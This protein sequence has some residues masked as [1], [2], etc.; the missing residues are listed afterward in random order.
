MVKSI[1]ADRHQSLKKLDE[2]AKI[3]PISTRIFSNGLKRFYQDARETGFVD[4]PSGAGVKAEVV[5][6]LNQNRI[7]LSNRKTRHQMVEFCIAHHIRPDVFGSIMDQ[8][9]KVNKQ[10]LYWGENLKRD[11][12][13]NSCLL[14]TSP[15]P[16]D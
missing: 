1:N 9:V 5:T 16:R 11:S 3:K 14:Y 7:N 6:F 2:L 12:S 13:V 10:Y 15:S 8:F 4:R